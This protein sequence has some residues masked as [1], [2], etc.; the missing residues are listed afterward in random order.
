[1]LVKNPTKYC[2]D[3][4]KFYNV[5]PDKGSFGYESSI[6]LSYYQRLYYELEYTRKVNGICFFF[7]LTYCDN[8]VP[9]FLGRNVHSYKDVRLV[10]NGSISKVLLR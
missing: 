9:K 3:Y 10:T 7:T 8:K 2:S 1:M 5:V 6:R 4:T